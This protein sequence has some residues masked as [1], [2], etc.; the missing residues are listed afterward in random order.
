MGE[1]GTY[2]GQGKARARPQSNEGMVGLLNVPRFPLFWITPVI[3]TLAI[4]ANNPRHRVQQ[5]IP[6]CL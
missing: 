2:W 5:L 6:D 4:V 3:G 1:D